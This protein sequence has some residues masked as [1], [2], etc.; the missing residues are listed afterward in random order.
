M[1]LDEMKDYARAE[2]AR[3]EELTQILALVQEFA[4]AAGRDVEVTA[5]GDGMLSLVLDAADLLPFGAGDGEG[6]KESGPAEELFSPPQS[7]SGGDEPWQTVNPDSAPEPAGAAQVTG[8]FTD[9]ERREVDRMVAGGADVPEIA[10]ALNR[11]GGPVATLVRHARKR[12]EAEPVDTVAPKVAE[13]AP[14]VA[15]A[16]A[17]VAKVAPEGAAPLFAESVP[18]ARAAAEWDRHLRRVPITKLFDRAMDLDLMES[19]SAGLK[20][21]DY[22]ATREL[23]RAE[24][25]G[26]FSALMGDR[27]RTLENQNACIAAL[28]RILAEA[29]A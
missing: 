29:A 17:P 13:V 16:P 21:A 8:P 3:A 26:R 18:K 14:E 7:V 28:R 22:A 12:L 19:L 27:A 6:A 11:A 24:V 20:A 4:A 9:A 15:P 23:T 2:M 10:A 5:D 25:A 1:R